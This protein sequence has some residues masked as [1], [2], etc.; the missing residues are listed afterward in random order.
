V[1]VESCLCILVRL[2]ILAERV[3][4]YLCFNFYYL[5][6]KDV[7]IFKKYLACF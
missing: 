5:L 3:V 7:L 6:T 1:I 2:L 4:S